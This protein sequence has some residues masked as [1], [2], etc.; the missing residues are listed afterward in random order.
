MANGWLQLGLL[1]WKCWKSEIRNPIRLAALI[2]V[3]LLMFIVLAGFRM[4][5]QLKDQEDECHFE[6]M[7]LPSSGTV[8][9]LQGVVC[10]YE[11]KCQKNI[12]RGEQGEYPFG[13]AP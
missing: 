6:S 11:N 1:I 8:P 9:Y 3:P 5:F 4:G 13:E 7:P 10:N 12:T 2:L